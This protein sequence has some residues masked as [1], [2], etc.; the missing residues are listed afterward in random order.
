LTDLD[1]DIVRQ[2]GRLLI[3]ELAGQLFDGGQLRVLNPTLLH[4]RI[5]LLGQGSVFVPLKKLSFVIAH[6]IT[7]KFQ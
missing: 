1:L 3:P 7:T 4:Q 2:R 6:K 5:V